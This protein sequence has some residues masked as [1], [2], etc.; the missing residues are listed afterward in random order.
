MR[1]LLSCFLAICSS[2]ERKKEEKRRG[3]RG[4]KR[5]DGRAVKLRYTVD[6]NLH[7]VEGHH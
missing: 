1:C 6:E 7:I 5:K 4:T 2:W 3:W